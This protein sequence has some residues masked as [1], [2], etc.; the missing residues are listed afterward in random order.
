MRQ[1]QLLLSVGINVNS[2]DDVGRTPLMMACFMRNLK[3]RTMVCE[4]L[5]E[6]GANIELLDMFNRNTIMYAC[7]TRNQYLLEKLLLF[8]DSDMNHTDKDGNTSLMYAAIEGDPRILKMIMDKLKKYGLSM[9]M[10]NKRGFTAYLLA[11]KNGNIECANILR[12]NEASVKVF[13][14]EHFWDGEQWI[15]THY[16]QRLR[17]ESFQ[18][19]RQQRERQRTTSMANRPVSDWDETT[20]IQRPKSIPPSFTFTTRGSEERRTSVKPVKLTEKY[21]WSDER[22]QRKSTTA[23]SDYRNSSEKGKGVLTEYPE[24]NQSFVTYTSISRPGT[25]SSLRSEPLTLSSAT[26]YAETMSSTSQKRSRSCLQRQELIKIFEQYSMSQMPIPPAI[27]KHPTRR[28]FGMRKTKTYDERRLE[29]PGSPHTTKLTNSP[30][31]RRQ[32]TM[33]RAKARH[34][35]TEIKVI[36]ALQSEEQETN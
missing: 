17:R 30:K 18:M 31:N 22:K 9:D 28:N 10:R 15:R 5:L 2:Q 20:L 26:N 35:K 11:L 32:S 24:D 16:V 7:A 29:V 14:L 27:P 21:A 3:H 4:L 19:E 6:H 33:L 13:D 1:I 25:N 8:M 34:V 23:S 36:S 12:D